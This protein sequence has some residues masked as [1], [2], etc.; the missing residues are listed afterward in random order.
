MRARGLVV[1][2][3]FLV[4]GEA[5]GEFGAVVGEDAMDREREAVE[6]AL[7]E[8]GRGFGRRLGRISR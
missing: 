1:G 4:D 7:E 6:K 2:F 8:G 3:V 5:V